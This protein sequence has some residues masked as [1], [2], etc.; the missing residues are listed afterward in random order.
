M[1]LQ[2]LAYFV[3]V[4]RVGSI[5]QAAANLFVSPQAISRGI[6]NLEGSLG[7]SLFSRSSHGVKLTLVGERF[8]EHVMPIMRSLNELSSVG[9]AIDTHSSQT[10]R[11]LIDTINS[12]G[13]KIYRMARN[14]QKEHPELNLITEF[15]RIQNDAPLESGNYDVMFFCDRPSLINP[16]MCEMYTVYTSKTVAIAHRDSSVSDNRLLSWASF[17][18]HPIF[19]RS[20]EIYYAQRIIQRCVDAGFYPKLSYRG[21]NELD[22][23]YFVKNNEGVAFVPCFIADFFVEIDSDIQ[24]LDFETGITTDYAFAVRRSNPKEIVTDFIQSV[25]EEFHRSAV[26]L[27]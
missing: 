15:A 27:L 23:F 24:I 3:E 9:A 6:K 11:L 10:I 8:L 25:S 5:G 13:Y 14:Y 2:E 12:F 17:S 16:Q 26:T 1:T 21:N 4:A 20:E 22:P 19:L 7:N 18:D